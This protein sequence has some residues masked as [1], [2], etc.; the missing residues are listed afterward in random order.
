MQMVNRTLAMLAFACVAACRQ[1]PA[2]MATPVPEIPVLL[3]KPQT[4]PL[5]IDLVAEIKAYREVD[6]RP[7]VSGIVAKRYFQPG[8]RVKEGDLLLTIDTRA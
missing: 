2:P 3:V 8:Q 1:Q 7:Q 4:T 5:S 6:L